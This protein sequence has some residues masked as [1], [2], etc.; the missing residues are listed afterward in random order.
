[1]LNIKKLLYIVFYALI[2][3]GCLNLPAQPESESREFAQMRPEIRR[4]DELTVAFSKHEMELDFRK[5]YYSSEAQLFTAIYEGLFTY[6][7]YSLEPV[8]AL[9]E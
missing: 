8:P 9:A 4:L 1:M 7:P 5:S 6:H 2:F 3:T